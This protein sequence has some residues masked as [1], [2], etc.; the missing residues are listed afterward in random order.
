MISHLLG[1][2]T[3]FLRPLDEGKLDVKDIQFLYLL[4]NPAGLPMEKREKAE[5]LG[6]YEDACWCAEHYR[7][8]EIFAHV[9]DFLAPRLCP[10][11]TKEQRQSLKNTFHL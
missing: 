11:A 10:T 1:V 3:K 8:E 9:V 5:I 2:A 7:F 6:I 4:Y